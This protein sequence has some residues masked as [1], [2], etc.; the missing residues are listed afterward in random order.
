MK[1]VE[2][3]GRTVDEAV[4]K[5]LAQLGVTRQGAVVEILQSPR[6]ALLGLGRKDAIVR[7]TVKEAEPEGRADV[8]SMQEPGL[9][10]ADLETAAAEVVARMTA[11]MGLDV[12]VRARGEGEHVVVDIAGRDVSA[13]IGRHGQTLDAIELLTALTL[14]NR[15]GRRIFLTLDAEGYREKRE[16]VLRDIARK[17][18]DRAARE[19]KPVFLDPMSARERRVVHLALRD[20]RRVTTSSVGENDDRRVVVHPSEWRRG[21]RPPGAP[22]DIDEDDSGDV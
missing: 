19:R 12:T 14:G 3:T 18:A 10:S 7:V 16:R 13:V 2:A 11:R 15:F 1:S 6:P 21:A 20:D 8:G 22:E 5:A 9:P 4:E 17:A